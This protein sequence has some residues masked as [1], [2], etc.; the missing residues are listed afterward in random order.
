MDLKS[1]PQSWPR[2]SRPRPIVAIGA[3]GIMRSAHL[4]AYQRLGF[5]VAGAYDQD[6]LKAAALAKDFGLPKA[7]GSLDEALRQE[8]VV[9]DLAVP[10]SAALG[11]L[12]RLPEGAAVL[13]QKPL[14]EDL[15]QASA[16]VKVCRQKKL[17]AAVNFQLRFSPNMLALR[18]VVQSGALGRLVD[19]DVRIVIDQPW[20]L[21]TFLKSLPRLE[22]LYHSIHYL[23][24]LRSLLGEPKG[25]KA[26]GAKHP[27]L[28]GLADARGSILLD[29]GPDLRCSLVMNH[30]HRQGRRHQASQLTL[31]GLEGAAVAGLGVNLDYPKGEADTLELSLGQGWQSLPLR[32]SWFTEAFEGPMS[33]LQRFVAGED[34]ALVSPVDDALKTMA[35]VEACYASE[36]GPSTPIPEAG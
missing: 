33:N 24:L 18:A 15:A 3:G 8:R 22:V 34:A 32:G 4:P 9:Y 2:P 12:E 16:I 29:Y 23:D 17:A 10:A 25:V 19:A 27:A 28:E 11:I 1:L 30:T 13:I 5:W 6:G 26:L 14:G 7:F 36:S 35:L 20:Q 21:W 31:E